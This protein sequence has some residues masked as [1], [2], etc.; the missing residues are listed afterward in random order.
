MWKAYS[1]AEYS[2]PE[3][4]I[5]V[6]VPVSAWCMLC[7]TSI[8]RVHRAQ[9]KG[10]NW[11]FMVWV[12]RLC[13]VL[14]WCY[15]VVIAT[16]QNPLGEKK[17]RKKKIQTERVYVT[18]RSLCICSDWTD[19]VNGHCPI[20]ITSVQARISPFVSLGT[21]WSIRLYNQMCTSSL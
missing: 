4:L 12:S 5:R 19:T 8:E 20:P 11:G 10:M 6:E 16:G 18:C 3:T 1:Y 9:G 7:K 15:R 14:W 2:L 13:L 17:R 21:L